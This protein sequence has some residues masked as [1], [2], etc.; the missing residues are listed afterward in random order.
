MDWDGRDSPSEAEAK[1]ELEAKTGGRGA[2]TQLAD[3]PI[4]GSQRH[5]TPIAFV[6]RSPPSRCGLFPRCMHCADSRKR[7]WPRFHPLDFLRHGGALCIPRFCLFHSSCGLPEC[8]LSNFLLLPGVAERA[9]ESPAEGER[10]PNLSRQLSPDVL[11][12]MVVHALEGLI[13]AR[14]YP[15]PTPRGLASLPP[16]SAGFRQGRSAHDDIVGMTE[17][18]QRSNCATRSSGGGPV[19]VAFL[20]RSQGRR[21]DR[22]RQG[23]LDSQTRR[24][25]GAH[26]AESQQSCAGGDCAWWPVR[27]QWRPDHRIDATRRCAQLSPLTLSICSHDARSAGRPSNFPTL[28]TEPACTSSNRPRRR[29]RCIPPFLFVGSLTTALWCRPHACKAVRTHSKRR[30]MRWPQSRRF[31]ISLAACLVVRRLCC[32]SLPSAPSGWA[33]STL[34][35]TPAV[36]VWAG[37]RCARESLQ[38]RCFD[39]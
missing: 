32:I 2:R 9:C 4:G 6:R 25:P 5:A 38:P 21:P 27:S 31:P 13:H 7:A 23:R 36:S 17:W 14:L 22:T 18:I 30:W 28:S 37:H 8:C 1:A 3:S 20:D 26:G 15:Y 19:P 16:R 10:R 29:R 35:D 33:R 34:G 39:C 24:V 11:T 12:S